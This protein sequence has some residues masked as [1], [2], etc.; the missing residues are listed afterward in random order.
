MLIGKVGEVVLYEHE[1]NHIFKKLRVGIV[2]HVFLEKQQTHSIDHVGVIPAVAQHLLCCV[3]MKFLKLAS[4]LKI[5]FSSVGIGVARD[6]PAT[7]VLATCCQAYFLRSMRCECA[8][9]LRHSLR[10]DEFSR[11]LAPIDVL[12]VWIRRIERVE[13]RYGLFERSHG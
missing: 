11:N 8:E 12:M 9:A 2:K 6:S 1:T 4:P 3:C 13:S 10:V 7:D 5:S